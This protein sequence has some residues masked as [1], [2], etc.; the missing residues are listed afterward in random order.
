MARRARS[1]AC[2]SLVL[3]I[4]AGVGHRYG[5]VETVAYFW[6]LA[7]VGG[8]ALLAL[9]LAASG[10][11]R[12]WVYGEKAGK[13]SLAAVVLAAV[14]LASYVAGAYFVVR[15]PVL[16][17]VSTDLVEPPQ[18]VLAPGRRNGAMNAIEP[19][20]HEAA[21]LQAQHYPDVSGRR[22]DAS[23]SRVMNAAA[24]VIAARGWTPYARL[25]LEAETGEVS[26]ELE[27]PT[28]LV[29]FPA[30][31][32]LRLTDEGASTFVDMRMNTR[33]AKHDL[34]DNARRIRAFMADLDAE[35][36]RQSL[37]IIDIPASNEEENPVD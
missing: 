5:L 34:G 37:E 22:Y 25:P 7:L 36:A 32:V 3:L 30:D 28:F 24:A 12:L 2:F 21:A 8:L 27:A 6:I 13:A 14:V 4:V 20:M 15:Y 10:F 19:I 29:R 9:G 23:M 18:F 33:Y 16:N 26:I 1:I 35:F 17:D 31:A 11:R